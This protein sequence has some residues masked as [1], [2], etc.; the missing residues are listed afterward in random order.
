MRVCVNNLIKG[1]I[2]RLHPTPHPPADETP[3]TFR[4]KMTLRR[5]IRQLAASDWPVKSDHPALHENIPPPAE[6]KQAAFVVAVI[7]QLR[8]NPTV[9]AI[10]FSEPPENLLLWEC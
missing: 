9:R 4:L 10:F 8:N 3:D 5:L 2:S 7:W 6:E 1:V